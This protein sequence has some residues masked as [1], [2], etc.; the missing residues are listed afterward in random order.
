MLARRNSTLKPEQTGVDKVLGF[1][2]ELV[3][4]RPNRALY[5]YIY[6][7]LFGRV[8]INNNNDVT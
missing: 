2:R 8:L 7:S 4:P 1:A 6:R 3:G 5:I